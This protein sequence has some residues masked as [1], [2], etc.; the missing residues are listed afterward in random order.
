MRQLWEFIASHLTK[1]KITGSGTTLLFNHEIVIDMYIYIYMLVY[2]ALY[3]L[4][5][6][7]SYRAWVDTYSR[8]F[9]L[10]LNL[11]TYFMR[12]HSLCGCYADPYSHPSNWQGCSKVVAGVGVLIGSP[13]TTLCVHAKVMVMLVG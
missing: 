7:A 4:T 5:I 8:F 12:C 1:R 11:T 9:L 13:A 6:L 10:V 2:V 3:P